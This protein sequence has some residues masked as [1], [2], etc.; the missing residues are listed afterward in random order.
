MILHSRLIL[1]LGVCLLVASSA[2][3]A[4]KNML[5]AAMETV[6]AQDLY[7]HV[8]VLADD[9]Y[10]GRAAGSRGGHAAAK[11][12]V[13][14]LKQYPLAPAGTDEAT[15]LVEG[16]DQARRRATLRRNPAAPG[17][18]EGTLTDLPDGQYQVLLVEPQ[19]SGEPPA[20]RFAVVSPAGEMARTEM[21]RAALTA[22]AESTHGKFFMAEDAGRLFDELPAGRRVPI[23]NLPP[24]PIWNRWWLL[25][26]FLACITAE[27]ILRKRKGML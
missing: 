17:V 18:F 12:I 9:V 27:W 3:G 25:S 24:V 8:E 6:T 14:Q 23:E 10:E 19:L 15:V 7:K 5:N 20:A 16:S 2:L 22:A 4:T 1:A 13:D 26:M 21:D 11:Y